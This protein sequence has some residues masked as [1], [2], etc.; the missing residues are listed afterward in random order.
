[1]EA[2]KVPFEGKVIEVC[3]GGNF[4]VEI[5]IGPDGYKEKKIVLAYPSG[6]VR[7]NA[8]TIVVGDTVRIEV[9]P[10]DL[11]KGRIVYRNKN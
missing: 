10:Y 2:D 7:K 8:I 5:E 1:M 3:R 11:S 9:S 6:K 4:K